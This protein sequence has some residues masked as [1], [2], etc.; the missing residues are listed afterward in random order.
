VKQATDANS[1]LMAAVTAALVQFGIAQQ[2]TQTSRFSIQPFYTNEPRGEPKLAGYS[3]SNQV[4]IKIREIG[5]IGDIL[6]RL[7]TVG[8]T[9]VSNIAF[10]VS[11]PSNRAQVVFFSIGGRTDNL[12]RRHRQVDVSGAPGLMLPVQMHGNRLGVAAFCAS[13]IIQSQRSLSMEIEGQNLSW[14]ERA[15]YVVLGLGIAA[16]G[17]KPRPNPVLNVLALGIGGFLAWAGYQGRCPVKAALMDRAT[18]NGRI[19]GRG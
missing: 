3:V 10:P 5:K 8:V 16:T 1:K 14:E 17:A 11:D 7:I 15:A 18:G 13:H 12:A 9:D 4:T 2:D 6:D 19:A